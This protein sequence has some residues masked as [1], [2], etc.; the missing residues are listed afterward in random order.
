MQYICY[1]LQTLLLE[2][3]IRI[4]VT[5]S[6]C[7]VEMWNLRKNSKRTNCQLVLQFLLNII[8]YQYHHICSLSTEYSCTRLSVCVC[9]C[10]CDCVQDNSKNNLK[11][12]LQLEHIVVPG[13]SSDE[14][15]I[16]HCPIK[17]KV[18]T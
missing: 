12:N 18:T 15:E 7:H 5:L 16:V 14:F 11:I 6:K 10:L 8:S 3:I 13:K 1:C 4:S 9:V 2:Y 17:V